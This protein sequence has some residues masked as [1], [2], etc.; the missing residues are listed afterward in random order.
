M[1]LPTLILHISLGLACAEQST[2]PWATLREL[3]HR[4]PAMHGAELEER[5]ERE[6]HIKELL[7][8]LQTD[9]PS[10]DRDQ[11]LLYV[12]ESENLRLHGLILEVT[13]E[14]P[15]DPC[16]AEAWMARGRALASRGD[17]EG[18]EEL[19]E[20]AQSHHGLASKLRGLHGIL[21]YAH[22]RAG[23]SAAAAAHG[24]S[25]ALSLLRDQS[26][27][28]SATA[29]LP[30]QA[31][32]TYQRFLRA[33]LADQGACFIREI[34]QLLKAN[35]KNSTPRDTDGEARTL[36]HLRMGALAQLEE[37]LELRF[38][39]RIEW[40]NWL[41]EGAHCTEEPWW[42]HALLYAIGDSAQSINLLADPIPLI[43]W[44]EFTRPELGS[45][46]FRPILSALDTLQ[47]RAQNRAEHLSRIRADRPHAGPLLV[48]LSNTPDRLSNDTR[49]ALAQ[50][51]L[52]NPSLTTVTRAPKDEDPTALF[53]PQWMIYDRD[54][55]LTEVLVGDGRRT[56]RLLN[57]ALAGAI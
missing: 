5:S 42:I 14:L 53:T 7:R 39:A 8:E 36:H 21:A 1:S 48:L 41:L 2:D 20:R 51:K 25:H 45:P 38:D 16:L 12:R 6:R 22:D 28:I 35:P 17:W 40:M 33:G 27:K 15:R 52:V 4:T 55:V 43:E 11:L 19:L 46:R 3:A 31:L 44:C 32:L 30:Q 47:A 54:G 57:E 56:R 26:D 13:A 18:A 9:L 29:A 23:D 50:A 49:G 24:R 37:A 34:T 10:A